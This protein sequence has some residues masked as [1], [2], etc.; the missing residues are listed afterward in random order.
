MPSIGE[1]GSVKEDMKYLVKT[2]ARAIDDKGDESCDDKR[3]D[4][5]QAIGQLITIGKCGGEERCALLPSGQQLDD[6]QV[7]TIADNYQCKMLFNKS[8]QI[9]GGQLKS[10]P[11]KMVP[12]NHAINGCDSPSAACSTPANG[13][14][15][16]QTKIDPLAREYK[17][18][19]RMYPRSLFSPLERG[20][21]G[22]D[23]PRPPRVPPAVNRSTRAA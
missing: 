21:R 5:P 12:L 11:R 19:C 8:S 20:A 15:G 10:P 22:L 2:R 9:S 17:P 4:Y 23:D 18:K 16:E 6:R 1:S 7:S 3:Q 13:P 14:D